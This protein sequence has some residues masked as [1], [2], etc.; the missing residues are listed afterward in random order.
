MERHG[1]GIVCTKRNDPIIF[2]RKKKRR[3]KIRNVLFFT[4]IK[5]VTIKYCKHLIQILQGSEIRRNYIGKLE[6]QK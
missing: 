2:K 1:K 6:R 4:S 5:N 3:E